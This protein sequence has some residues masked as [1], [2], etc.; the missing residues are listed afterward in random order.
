MMSTHQSLYYQNID[1]LLWE[2]GS[3][4][5]DQTGDLRPQVD[6]NVCLGFEEDSA[7]H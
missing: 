6:G 5:L 3:T 2:D 1:Q 7:D 4:Q